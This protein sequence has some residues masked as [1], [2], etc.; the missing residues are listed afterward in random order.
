MVAM[1]VPCLNGLAYFVSA[2][3]GDLWSATH[4]G[5]TISSN[6]MFNKPPS[7]N[8]NVDKEQFVGEAI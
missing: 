3:I 6:P 4:D 8:D 7:G 5:G 2:A 1:A